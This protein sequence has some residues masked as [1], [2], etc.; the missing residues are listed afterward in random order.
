MRAEREKRKRERERKEKE[1]RRRAANQGWSESRD[2]ERAD[3]LGGT[4][5]PLQERREMGEGEKVRESAVPVF[6]KASLVFS[7]FHF[8][9]KKER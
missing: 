1:R 3:F 7:L 9:D 2:Q 4:A 5:F 6:M 8:R